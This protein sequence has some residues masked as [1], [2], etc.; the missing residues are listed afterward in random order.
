MTLQQLKYV[1]L[2]AE[3]GSMNEAAKQLFLS[4]PSLSESVKDLEN[5]IGIT[6][7]NRTN[8]GI[9]ITP[10]GD[11]FLGYV[12]QTLS[13]YSL[14]EERYFESGTRKKHFRVSTQ[15][16]TFAVDAFAKMMK[17]FDMDKYDFGIFE[18]R[19]AEIIDDVSSFRRNIGV[20]YMDSENRKMLTKLIQSRNCVFV[21]LFQCHIYAYVS[22][23]HPFAQKE[24][25]TLED[26][27]EYTCMTFDQGNNNAFYLSEEVFHPT[28]FPRTLKVNDRATMLNMMVALKGYTLCSGIICEELKGNRYAAVT[29][30]TEQVMEIGYSIS[31]NAGMNKLREAYIEELIK[32]KDKVL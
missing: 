13:Q 2:I 3:T 5:E 1:A 14:L 16:Y 7:F 21:P 29:V 26:L 10:E 15:H 11:E 19:T 8:R 32:Y 9:T 12:R 30:D 31:K 24:K 18:T 6:I 28:E 17:K 22:C 20:L 4:Q 23:D 25:V 27:K